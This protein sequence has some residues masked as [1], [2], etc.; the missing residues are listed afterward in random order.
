MIREACPLALRK[1][2]EV[3]EAEKTKEATTN[4]QVYAQ[5]LCIKIWHY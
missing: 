2:A 3:I 4:S 5:Y 1:K